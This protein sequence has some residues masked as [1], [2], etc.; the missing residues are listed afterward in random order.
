[1]KFQLKVN[2]RK[3]KKE[4]KKGSVV[5]DKQVGRY[6]IRSEYLEPVTKGRKTSKKEDYTTQEENLLFDLYLELADP[7]NNSDNRQDIIAEFRSVYDTHT[8]DSLEIFING[9]KRIDYEYLAEGMAPKK[10]TVQKL[11]S[12]YP[13]R[14]MTVDELDWTRS[15]S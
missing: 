1:M 8:D 5:T 6:G 13:D 12:I 10:A 15:F 14:F 2:L 4:F 11:N 9:L 7:A 3:G